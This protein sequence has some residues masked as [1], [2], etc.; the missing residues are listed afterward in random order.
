GLLGAITKVV[1]GIGLF[2]SHPQANHT[3]ARTVS[4][5][6]GRVSRCRWTYEVMEHKLKPQGIQER[7]RVTCYVPIKIRSF[8]LFSR[9]PAQPPTQLRRVR[10]ERRQVQ[11]TRFVE[12]VPRE[13]PVNVECSCADGLLTTAVWIEVK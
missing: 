3:R 4:S 10:S 6:D 13:P 2:G 1:V 12:V 8:I 7:Y 11:A 9:I 5:Y